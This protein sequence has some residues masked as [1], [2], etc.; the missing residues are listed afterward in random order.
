M[1]IPE[2]LTRIVQSHWFTTTILVVIVANAVVL[3]L[4]TYAG[5]DDRYGDQLDLVND[6]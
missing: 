5:I 3:G 6:L 4:E 2:R 1:S